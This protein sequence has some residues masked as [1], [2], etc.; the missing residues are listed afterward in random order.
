M[1]QTVREGNSCTQT[2][3]YPHPWEVVLAAYLARF[4]THPRLPKLVSSEVSPG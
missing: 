4:P 1:P 3:T 2:H